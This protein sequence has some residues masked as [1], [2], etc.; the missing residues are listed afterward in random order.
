MEDVKTPPSR[1]TPA[2]GNRTAVTKT[3]AKSKAVTA[4]PYGPRRCF[5]ARVERHGRKPLAARFGGIPLRRQKKAAITHLPQGP[6]RP[7]RKQ[8]V[9]RPLP[10]QFDALGTPPPLAAPLVLKLP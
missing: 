9:T 4:T 6:A 2:H 1:D 3:A 10:W 7:P 8:L 5:E